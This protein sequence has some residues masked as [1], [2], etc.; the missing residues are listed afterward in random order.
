TAV[1]HSTFLSGATPSVSGII[2]NEWYDRESGKNVTSVSDPSSKIVGGIPGM[3]GSS[4]RRLMVSTVSD[5]LKMQGQTQGNESRVIGVSIKDRGAILPSGHMTD[6]AYWYD[7]DSNH[8]VTS[9][10]YRPELPKWV[11]ELNDQHIGQR[12]LGKQWEPLDTPEGSA[13]PY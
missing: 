3:E 2:A 12:Y 5:E 6:A 13:K 4:P 7:S 1:G 9:S 11:D 10:Y 8:W